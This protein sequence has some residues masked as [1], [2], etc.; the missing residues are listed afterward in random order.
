MATLFIL[1][2]WVDM[3]M[4]L[5]GSLR[6]V[7]QVSESSGE[8][9]VGRSRGNRKRRTAAQDSAGRRVSTFADYVSA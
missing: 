4:T 3:D 9:L 1:L 6:V 8:A 2:Y 5:L 7:H